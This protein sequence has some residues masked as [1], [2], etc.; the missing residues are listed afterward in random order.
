MARMW[1]SRPLIMALVAAV[2]VFLRRQ[3]RRQHGTVLRCQCHG[4]HGEVYAQRAKATDGAFY[5]T[6]CWKGRK[7]SNASLH[8]KMIGYPRA[9]GR[10]VSY[11][12]IIRQIDSFFQHYARIIVPRSG[13]ADGPPPFGLATSALKGNRRQ[14]YA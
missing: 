4:G 10:Y 13:L 12:A 3:R 8:P 11:A 9:T 2:V 5:C 14:C 1:L 7:V 6:S